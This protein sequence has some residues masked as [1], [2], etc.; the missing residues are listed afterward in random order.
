MSATGKSTVVRELRRRGF[1]A[2]DAD[3]DGCTEPG[4]A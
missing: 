3:D 2:Y 1:A 4:A